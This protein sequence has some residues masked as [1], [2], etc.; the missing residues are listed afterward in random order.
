MTLMH[1]KTPV[2]LSLAAMA[3]ALAPTTVLAE[4]A[5]TSDNTEA[6]D[7]AL[8]LFQRSL[9]NIARDESKL[10][11]SMENGSLSQEDFERRAIEL[12]FR[13]DELIT[14]DPHNVETLILYGK[15]L[16]RIGKNDQAHAMFIHADHLS[17]NIAVLKQQIG[18]YLAEQGNYPEA[19]AYYLKAVELEPKEAVYHYGLGELMATFRDKFVTDGAFTD[20]SIDGEILK[21]FAKAEELDP[22]NKDFAFRHAEAYYDLK[23]PKWD[24]ALALWTKLSKRADLSRY[25]RDAIRLHMSRINCE[26]GNNKEALVLVHDDVVPLLQ[27]TRARLLKRLNSLT[28]IKEDKANAEVTAPAPAKDAATEKTEAK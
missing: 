5:K 3:F 20:D 16:R 14:R 24:D 18:N 23:T 26:L 25:E 1:F 10:F 9:F 13:Y 11:S 27:A 4:K 15:F 28:T 8:T 7:D 6:T 12:S 19:L 21:S 22:K 2:L 17:P